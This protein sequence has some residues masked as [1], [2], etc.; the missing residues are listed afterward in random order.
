MQNPEENYGKFKVDK[1]MSQGWEQTV[2]VK[3]GQER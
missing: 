2:C 1:I 3:H